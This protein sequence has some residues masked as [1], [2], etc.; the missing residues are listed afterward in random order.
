MGSLTDGA[1]I[2]DFRNWN[3]IK[4]IYFH[5][6]FFCF[7]D[8]KSIQTYSNKTGSLLF[9]L[10]EANRSYKNPG[11]KKNKIKK[12]WNYRKALP[13]D[14]SVAHH[15]P[16]QSPTPVLSLTPFSPHS[17]LVIPHSW[18]PH[19]DANVLRAFHIQH[20]WRDAPLQ[21]LAHLLLLHP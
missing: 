4:E 8:L 10:K 1:L 16:V 18:P 3:M 15:L 13:A 19:H 5:K 20:Q 9:F 6:N 17:C 11:E 12:L 2:I 7:R 21:I 14:P